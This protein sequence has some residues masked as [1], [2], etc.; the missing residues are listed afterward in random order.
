MTSVIDRLGADARSLRSQTSELSEKSEQSELSKKSE[1]SEL[2]FGDSVINI[3]KNTYADT[4]NDILLKN[5]MDNYIDRW[6]IMIESDAPV[7]IREL[8]RTEGTALFELVQVYKN[9]K[10]KQEELILQKKNNI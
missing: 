5:L 3:C 8:L 4:Y 7:E 1:Q 10:K 9:Q 6:T 2:A